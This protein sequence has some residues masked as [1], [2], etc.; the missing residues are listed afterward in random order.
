MNILNLIGVFA[1]FS[2][3]VVETISTE[4]IAAIYD[5]HS[6]KIEASQED[7]FD[8][9]KQEI[10]ISYNEISVF[11]LLSD[12]DASFTAFKNLNIDYSINIPK[13][14]YENDEYLLADNINNYL[15]IERIIFWDEFRYNISEIS[16]LTRYETNFFYELI[17]TYYYYSDTS[18]TYTPYYFNSYYQ[19]Y[20]ITGYAPT[21]V[22]IYGSDSIGIYKNYTLN[23]ETRIGES[24][25]A[26]NNSYNLGFEN[27]EEIGYENGYIQ[28]EK[29]GYKEG[30]SAGHRFNNILQIIQRA[31]DIAA[32]ILNIEIFPGITLGLCFGIP[33]ILSIVYFVLRW[34]R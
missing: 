21:S 7:F 8:N 9:D 13:Y 14:I 10:E 25:F 24:F 16:G 3:S 26:L 12:G 28:G 23:Y 30:Y 11:Q 4:R 18:N 32:G 17:L 5:N 29:D 1:L 31:F 6:L 15:K 20:D 34:F 2:F 19:R 33:L 22:F 27:G